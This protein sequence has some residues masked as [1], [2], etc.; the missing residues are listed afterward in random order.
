MM[1]N[2]SNINNTSTFKIFGHMSKLCRNY[3]SD[4]KHAASNFVKRDIEI[5]S[6]DLK[7]LGLTFHVP[8]I[9]TML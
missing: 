9:K 5:M 6:N 4:F 1:F 8:F 3:A 2:I 7:L